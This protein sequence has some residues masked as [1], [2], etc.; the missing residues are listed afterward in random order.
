MAPRLLVLVDP[1]IGEATSV[2]GGSII[3]S[4]SMPASQVETPRPSSRVLTGSGVMKGTSLFSGLLT[5][6]AGEDTSAVT[7][8]MTHCSSCELVF[9]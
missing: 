3:S 2:M 8:S 9:C 5:D 1:R 7:S 6:L 4:L